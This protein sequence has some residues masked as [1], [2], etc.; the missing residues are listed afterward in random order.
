MYCRLEEA[1]KAVADIRE[2]IDQ[3]NSQLC[4]AEAEISMLKRR[5]E[6]L[7]W[8]KEKDKKQIAQLQDALNRAR[9]VSNII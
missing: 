7:T 9:I 8:D 1:E 2:K 6:G 4:D 3:Q 5:I